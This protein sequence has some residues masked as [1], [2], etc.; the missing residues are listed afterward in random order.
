MSDIPMAKTLLRANGYKVTRTEGGFTAKA[1]VIALMAGVTLDFTLTHKDGISQLTAVRKED[2]YT[3]ELPLGIMSLL[4]VA[5]EA[6][7]LKARAER[8]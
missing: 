2:G 4:D 1:R 8:S 3:A 7:D 6:V 5:V